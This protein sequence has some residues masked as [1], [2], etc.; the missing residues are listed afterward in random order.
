[1]YLSKITNYITIKMYKNIICNKYINNIFNG[2][3]KVIYK[4]IIY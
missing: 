1:M 2:Y 3:N 4:N